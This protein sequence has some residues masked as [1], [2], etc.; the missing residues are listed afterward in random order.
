[1]ASIHAN[2][3]KTALKTTEWSPCIS[4][5]NWMS[6]YNKNKSFHKEII[7]KCSATVN[8]SN[9]SKEV[10]KKYPQRNTFK[11]LKSKRKENP[12]ENLTVLLSFHWQNCRSVIWSSKTK[13][14]KKKWLYLGN[15]PFLPVSRPLP[16]PQKK[17]KM[18][19]MS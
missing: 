2:T 6:C 5:D 18:L 12:S 1:M 15:T 17:K 8:F 7:I 19:Q 14:D 11:L 10:H 16:S 4:H 9:I 3:Q 13:L